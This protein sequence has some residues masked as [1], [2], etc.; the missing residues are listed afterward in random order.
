[1]GLGRKKTDINSSQLNFNRVSFLIEEREN[2][3]DGFSLNFTQTS[4]FGVGVRVLMVFYLIIYGQH[5]KV[6]F[7]F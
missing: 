1:M 6:S 7:W 4:F 3:Q 2:A 5:V